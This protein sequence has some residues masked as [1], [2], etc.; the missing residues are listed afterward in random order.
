MAVHLLG[1]DELG[2]APPHLGVVVGGQ[3]AGGRRVVELGDPQ[4]AAVHPRH[5]PPGGIGPRVDHR[6]GHVEQAGRAG[7]E[8]GDDELP[9]QRADRDDDGP[10]RWRTR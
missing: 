1:G 8:I 4:G 2:D 7:H 10:G 9:G 6:A 3:D 5:P